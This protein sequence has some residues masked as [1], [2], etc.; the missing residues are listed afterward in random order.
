MKKN[1]FIRETT[2]LVLLQYLW[3]SRLLKA[4]RPFRDDVKIILDKLI[5]ISKVVE[6][7]LR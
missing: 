1:I 4:L 2:G 7:S 6:S 5:I 3:F